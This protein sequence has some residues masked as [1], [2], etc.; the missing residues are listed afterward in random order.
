MAPMR[1]HIRHQLLSV[2]TSRTATFWY[3]ARNRMEMLY[4]EEFRELDEKFANFSYKVAL[5]DPLP[6]DKWDGPTGFIHQCLYEE[7]LKDH[8]DPSE[9][10][11]YL[12]G[13]PPMIAAVNAMLDSLG[14][15]PEMVLYDAFS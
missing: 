10:E 7:Y 14:V 2:K 1:S 5:S 15:E 9:I 8:P 6:D 13:P 11:Y 12:C 3:G 4:D